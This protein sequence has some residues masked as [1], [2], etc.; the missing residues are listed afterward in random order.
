MGQ[1]SKLDGQ[2]FREFYTPASFGIL[3]STLREI[4][5]VQWKHFLCTECSISTCSQK[6]AATLQN[7]R[8]SIWM[9]K[10]CQKIWRTW[11][12]TRQFLDHTLF[13]LLAIWREHTFL[14][15]LKCYLVPFWLSKNHSIINSKFLSKPY[16]F[17]FLSDTS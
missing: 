10:R 13:L 16:I 8:L 2:E 15:I 1:H 9:R 6:P 4:A 11:F 7:K 17:D 14:N 3:P 5:R 12:L